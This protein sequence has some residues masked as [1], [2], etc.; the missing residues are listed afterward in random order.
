MNIFIML[1]KLF[2][3]ESCRLALVSVIGRWSID[4]YL[5]F[6]LILLGHFNFLYLKIDKL[7]FIKIMKKFI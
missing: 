3:A 4:N 1:L 2:L 6:N 5:A 7:Y